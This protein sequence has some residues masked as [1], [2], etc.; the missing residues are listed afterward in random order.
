MFRD[1]HIKKIGLLMRPGNKVHT[2]TIEA[3]NAMTIDELSRYDSILFNQ[4]KIR[5]S[6]ILCFY[7]ESLRLLPIH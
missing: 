4:P 1:T 3:A 2:S 5:L 7:F 6:I